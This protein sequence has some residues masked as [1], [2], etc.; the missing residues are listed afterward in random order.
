VRSAFGHCF[1]V[2]DGYLNTASI[3][4]PP[5]AVA[6]AVVEAV[7]GWRGGA[8]R[9]PDFDEPVA[10]ARAAFARLVGVSADRVAISGSVSPLVGLVAANLPA[11]ARVLVPRGEFTSVTFPFAVQAARGVVV[12]EV[13]L[14]QLPARAGEAD[15]VAC[16]VV[17][18]A[19]GALVDLDALR[20]HTADTHTRVLLDATQAV[21]WLPLSLGWADAV[22]AAGY[23][24]LLC[25]RG[26]AWLAVSER[27][28]D[29]LVPHAANW[30]AGEDRWAS[31]YDL[32]PELA[33][34][35]RRLDASPAWFS[36]VGAAVALPWLASLDA[37]AVRAHCVG[38]ANQLRVGLGQR[39]SDSAITVVDRPGA[40][41]RLAAAGV[42]A[43]TRRGAARLACHLYNTQADVERALQ[44]LNRTASTHNA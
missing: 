30:Y 23:K 25:P 3:G 5:V 37:E 26:A 44:A 6:D 21:G 41:P 39:P 13:D 14:T 27:L 18:S 42:V 43:S 36:H 2:P 19:D 33:G 17:Q 32:P 31:V 38:L 9:A 34:D 1:D 35:A 12:T 16:S 20:A 29:T 40:A 24:W 11:G 10:V 7:R 15:L 4:V 8:R 22:V 28:G